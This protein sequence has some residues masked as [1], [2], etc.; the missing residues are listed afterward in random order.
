MT[1][2]ARDNPHSEDIGRD[3]NNYLQFIEGKDNASKTF[4]EAHLNMSAAART[5]SGRIVKVFPL[6]VCPYAKQLA[7]PFRNKV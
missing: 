1:S 4:Q 7:F 3:K 6:P 2:L 5:G